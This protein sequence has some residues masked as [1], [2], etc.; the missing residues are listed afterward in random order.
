MSFA[1]LWEQSDEVK[2]LHRRLVVSNIM[3][4]RQ[5]QV[6]HRRVVEHAAQLEEQRFLQQQWQTLQVMMQFTAP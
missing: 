1:G 4:E 3:S 6:A 5:A 2:G